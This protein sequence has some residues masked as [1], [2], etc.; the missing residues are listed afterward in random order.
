M[1][2]A[3]FAGLTWFLRSMPA[4]LAGVAVTLAFWAAAFGLPPSYSNAL[5]FLLGLVGS[6]GCGL[7]GIVAWW[8]ARRRDAGPE[9]PWLVG[10]VLAVLPVILLG[11]R[12]LP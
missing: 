8:R 4:F 6:A 1:A 2:A 7:T 9:W 10:S 3:I 5:W 12:R 11:L